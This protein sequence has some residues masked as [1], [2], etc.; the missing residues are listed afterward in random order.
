[1]NETAQPIDGYSQEESDNIRTTFKKMQ[2]GDFTVYV[3]PTDFFT[4][5]DQSEPTTPIQSNEE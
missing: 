3:K 2:W 4:A 5:Q 1:M